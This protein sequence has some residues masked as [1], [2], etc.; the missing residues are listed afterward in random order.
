[1]VTVEVGR[2]RRHLGG[3]SDLFQ[4]L[5]FI[6]RCYY[7]PEPWEMYVSLRKSFAISRAAPPHRTSNRNLEKITRRYNYAA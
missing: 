7:E 2:G 5:H 1:M 4:S 6:R 3:L